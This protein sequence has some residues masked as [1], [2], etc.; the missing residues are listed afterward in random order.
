LLNPALQMWLVMLHKSH[1]YTSAINL[2]VVF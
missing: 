2:Q 1:M